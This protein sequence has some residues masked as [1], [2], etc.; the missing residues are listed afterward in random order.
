VPGQ[1]PPA[2]SDSGMSGEGRSRDGRAGNGEPS[3]H[4][5]KAVPE[6]T[7]VGA[8]AT[9]YGGTALLQAGSLRARPDYFAAREITRALGV[10]VG[11]PPVF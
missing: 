8:R 11:R 7:E 6:G 10:A 3:G 4:G 5:Q 9:Y 2:Y 1:V